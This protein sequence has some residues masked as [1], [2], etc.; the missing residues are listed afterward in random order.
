MATTEHA[1]C[2]PLGVR[3]PSRLVLLVLALALPVLPGCTS[4]GGAFDL[5][6]NPYD[7][8]SGIRLWGKDESK[9]STTLPA[10]EGSKRTIYDD[11]ARVDCEE[12]KRLYQAQEY[13]KAEKI[14][15]KIVKA[16]KIRQDVQEDAAFY[17]GECQRLQG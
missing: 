8:P 16:K 14:F 11:K 9:A 3:R 6:S 17:Y 1:R 15:D 4:G 7:P 10:A 2:G 13:A 12:A 5:Q